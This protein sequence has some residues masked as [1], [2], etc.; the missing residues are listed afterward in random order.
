MPHRYP[1]GVTSAPAPLI[2]ALVRFSART[3]LLP[4]TN[5][6]AETAA[7]SSAA[8]PAPPRPFTGM[9]ATS[10]TFQPFSE[11]DRMAS[12]FSHVSGKAA[13]TSSPSAASFTP[14]TPLPAAPC[15]FTAAG[16]IRSTFPRRVTNA[17]CDPGASTPERRSADIGT[18]LGGMDRR[19]GEVHQREWSA[20]QDPRYSGG[21]GY[22]RAPAH[23]RFL[24]RRRPRT[25]AVLVR[26]PPRQPRR[27]ARA[28]IRPQLPV[29]RRRDGLRRPHPGPY[30]RPHVGGGLHS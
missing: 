10:V 17:R 18:W 16:S 1:A 22:H 6:V 24:T 3:V 28:L 15:G 23:H 21:T 7:A 13:I 2:E 5:P 8:S 25:V 19:A 9:S 26:T 27:A 30:D 20:V 14:A 12:P 11:I 29:D 4:R